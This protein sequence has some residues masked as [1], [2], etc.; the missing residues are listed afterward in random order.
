MEGTGAAQWEAFNHVL[1]Y[2]RG[3][4]FHVL[5]LKEH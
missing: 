4:E 5:L 1:I 2:F 3:T